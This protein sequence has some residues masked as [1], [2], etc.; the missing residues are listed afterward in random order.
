MWRDFNTRFEQILENLTRHKNLVA[1]QAHLLSMELSQRDSGKIHDLFRQYM[2]D[3]D[4]RLRDTNHME[5]LEKNKNYLA[6]ISWLSTVDGGSIKDHEAACDR[7]SQSGVS[8]D[9]ILKHEKVQNWRENDPPTSSILW[10]TGK[11]GAGNVR[12]VTTH[13]HIC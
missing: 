10:L 2:I 4:Q 3:R 7:R 6:I 5:G 11:P 12:P 13:G 8:G 9:W 1:E